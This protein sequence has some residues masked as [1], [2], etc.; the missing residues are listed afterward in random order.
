MLQLIDCLI[1]ARRPHTKLRNIVDLFE[2]V[3]FYAPFNLTNVSM[4]YHNIKIILII[5]NLS[6]KISDGA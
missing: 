6:L 3:F 5:T 2:L 1:S 4:V